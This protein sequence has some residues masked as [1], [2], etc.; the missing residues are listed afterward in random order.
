MEYDLGSAITVPNDGVSIVK[1]SDHFPAFRLAAGADI[2]T[3]YRFVLPERLN[4]FAIMGTIRADVQPDGYLF[5]VVNP[6]DTMV[7][8]G[9]KLA[10]TANNKLNISLIYADARSPPANPNLVT[11]QVPYSK[12]W[13]SIAFKV[14]NEKVIFYH[15]C[16]NTETI[17]VSKEPKDLVFASASTFYI[18]QAGPMI[19]GKFEVNLFDSINALIK[20][21]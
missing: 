13:M 3:P 19:P 17:E 15:N 11:F 6:L 1:G 4:E 21:T 18:S 9:I 16:I 2:K 12:S 5:A 10:K 20:I 7:Q 8:L 14:M